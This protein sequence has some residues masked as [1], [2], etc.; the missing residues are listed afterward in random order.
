MKRFAYLCLLFLTLSTRAWAQSPARDSV[1]L[2]KVQLIKEVEV[3]GKSPTLRTG[4]DKKVFAVNQSLI[5]TAGSATDLLQN[6]PT[7]QLDAAGNISLRGAT[8]VKVLVDGK[9][10][11]I[12]GGSIAQLLQ[13][14]PAASIEKVEIITNPSAKQVAEGQAIIN[15]ILKK[16]GKSNDG[17][18][19]ASAGT[20]GNYNAGTSINYR[21]AKAEF[22]GIYTF[23]RRN[24]YSNGFQYM[25]YLNSTDP[26]YYSNEWFPSATIRNIHVAQTGVDYHLSSDDLLSIT[27]VYNSTTTDRH[28]YLTVDNLTRQKTPAQL[29]TRDN[30]TNS[31]NANG[32]ATIDLAHKFKRVGEQL[33]LDLAASTG[34]GSSFQV[35]S[36]HIF[37]VDGHSITPAPDILQD[38]K[39]GN[40]RNYN[41]Q[42]DYT[43][44]IGTTGRLEAGARS[45]LATGN[46][47]QWDA[48][49]DTLTKTYNPD[50]SLINF[51]KTNTQVH[52][53]YFN[54]RQQV[55]P[56][57]L[58]AGLRA[59]AGRFAAT[60]QN[61]DSA[62]TL[63]STPVR[64][65]TNGLYP[66][67]YVTRSLQHTQQLQL[68]YTR[69]INRP[70]PEE[71][72]PFPDVSDPVNYDEGNPRLRPEDIH[73]AEFTYKKTWPTAW[74]STGL[75]YHQVN[76]VI[77][78]I[79]TDPINDVT[80]TT[81]ENLKR[82]INTGL[83]LL[84]NVKV[85]GIWTV[86][87][88]VNIYDRIN[89]AAP[90]YGIAATSGITWNGNITNDFALARGLSAQIRADYKAPEVILQD[91]YRH[92]YGLDLGAKYDFA[93]H[94]ATLSFSGRDI[95]NIRR[96]SFLRVS[97]AL[98]LDWQRITYSARAALTLTWRF[99][100]DNEPKR[101]NRPEEQ[102]GKRI[103]NR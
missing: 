78:H 1:F 17:S 52:A 6:I 100:N 45:Q 92:A 30:T 99:G 12:G 27:A 71:L 22:Y 89:S 13:S 65:N 49:L 90:Q 21:A 93:H 33:D 50:F 16:G 47:R 66:A 25:T 76:N 34:S 103:E 35:Y 46:N 19:T 86:T 80:I 29:S 85:S 77:K 70:T 73:S 10:S 56:Y 39:G 57:T 63:V 7:L 51:F 9:Q 41:F 87:A 15:I 24:T 23:Q 36:T 28:E 48:S 60:L 37:N 20:R 83:E 81:G 74:I 64:I 43:L 95:F 61:Y 2:N 59:E 88:N 54:Y 97:D 38:T 44:P 18:L 53:V 62:G 42:L 91:R 67:F 14:I 94:R 84:G 101:A 4:T 72:N 26:T 102:Q 11:L 31:W 8:N 55:G 69:R 96:P 5:S 79:Q 58:Q 32:T 82:A 75:Y 98:L 40:K 3:V 68:S